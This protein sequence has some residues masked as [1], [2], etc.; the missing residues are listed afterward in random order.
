MF[1]GNICYTKC[2]YKLLSKIRKERSKKGL[3]IEDY[4]QH[5]NN[6]PLLNKK[7][8]NL[9]NNKEAIIYNVIKKWYNGWFLLVKIKYS[10]GKKHNVYWSNISC[11]DLIIKS[12]IENDSNLYEFLG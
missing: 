11:W 7:I 3:P 9:E 6:S 5:L 1:K 8:K 2:D 10:D 4:N 12:K